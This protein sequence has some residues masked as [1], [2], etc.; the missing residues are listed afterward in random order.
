MHLAGVPRGYVHKW[1]EGCTLGMAMPGTVN[2]ES[3]ERWHNLEE[4]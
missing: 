4:K 1:R 2:M 3:I